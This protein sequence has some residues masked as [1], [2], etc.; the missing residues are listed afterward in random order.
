MTWHG[1]QSS[2]R[3]A[4][5]PNDLWDRLGPRAARV[6][7]TLKGKIGLSHAFRTEG[8]TNCRIQ[9]R[10]AEGRQ[11]R[12]LPAIC[13]ATLLTAVGDAGAADSCVGHWDTSIGQPGLGGIVYDLLEFNGELIAG[14]NFTMSGNVT[15]NGTARWDGS[16]WHPL[17]EGVGGP[18]WS[19][20]V[21]ALAEYQGDLI[22]GGSFISA[23]GAPVD[24]IARWDGSQWH[25]LG[26]GVNG[27]ITALSVYNG[28]LIAGGSFTRAGEVDATG[29]AR[30]D[31]AAWRPLGGGVDWVTSSADA[32]ANALYVHGGDLIVGGVFTTAGDV[33]VNHAARWDG[34]D[35][36]AMGSVSPQLDGI[37]DLTIHDGDLFAGGDFWNVVRQWDGSSWQ[38]LNGG[39]PVKK[40]PYVSAL[41]S[42]KGYLYVGGSFWNAG[43]ATD[44]SNI[45]RWD[46]SAWHSVGSGI[47]TGLPEAM[48]EHAGALIVG[49]SFGSDAN[50][51]AAWYGCPL[52][53]PADLNG[54]GSMSVLDL[55]ILLENWGECPTLPPPPPDCC[56]ASSGVGCPGDP[57]CEAC[58]CNK[59]PFCC[60]T[61]W[62]ALCAEGANDGC[63][64]ECLCAAEQDLCTGDLNG[65]GQVDVDDLLIL[66]ANWG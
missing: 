3:R 9:G 21:F 13:A 28:E 44:T 16:T 55:L 8:T 66:L 27:T 23:G 4:T 59:D 26:E 29:I 1:E 35:W 48:V 46:G 36:H 2:L 52:P 51:V 31:G 41:A 32:A 40:H 47:I 42:Y 19:T 15:V 22:A 43:G 60:N 57:S 53:N 37:L 18:A 25:P 12:F 65:D 7:Y 64:Q 10:H 24:R 63:A 45:A 30:W 54:D 38:P 6:V 58:V 14:G 17:G 5:A 11:V 61:Q 50:G 20:S 49:G 39:S 34:A 33:A 56:N 62:D